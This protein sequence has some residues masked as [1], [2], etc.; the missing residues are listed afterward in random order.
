MATKI[1]IVSSQPS[2]KTPGAS[3]HRLLGKQ[4]FKRRAGVPECITD[5]NKGSNNRELFDFIMHDDMN[6]IKISSARNKYRK[7]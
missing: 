3:T 7:K 1:K 4:S 2:K 6:L 5:L